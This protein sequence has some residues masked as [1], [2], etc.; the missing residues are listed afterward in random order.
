MKKKPTIDSKMLEAMLSPTNI[1]DESRNPYQA[2]EKGSTGA[3]Y[4]TGNAQTMDLD[5][6][7]LNVGAMM[8]MAHDTSVANQ[9]EAVPLK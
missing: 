8:S 4:A 5:R 7:T 3:M 2:Q 6:S 9:N 1:G